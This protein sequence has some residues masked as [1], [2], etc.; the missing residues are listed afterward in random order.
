M[1]LTGG[2]RHLSGAVLGMAEV[3][4]PATGEIS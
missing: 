3:V 4:L 1:P 2:M